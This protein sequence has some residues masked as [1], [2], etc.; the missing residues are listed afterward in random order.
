MTNLMIVESPAKCKT[1]EGYLGEDWIVK[2]SS[3]HIR[4]LPV[5]EMGISF[6]DYRP[7]Y[8]LNSKSRR[9]IDAIKKLLPSVSQVY[10]ATDTDH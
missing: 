1:I 3:G 7:H 5:K 6:P 2:A 9:N 10:L 8:T 4:D